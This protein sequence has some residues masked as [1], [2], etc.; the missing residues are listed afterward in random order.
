VLRKPADVGFDTANNHILVADT[1]NHLIRLYDA[2]SLTQVAAI[3]TVGHPGRDNRHLDQ[4]LSVALNETAGQIYVAD[5][6]NR[7]IQIFDAKTFAHIASLETAGTEAIFDPAANRILV[8]D[9]ARMRV[10]SYDA[11]RFT[12]LSQ[13]GTT[14]RPGNDA[15]HFAAPAAL[16]F[17][18]AAKTILVADGFPNDRVQIFEA[19]ELR[20][21]S[22]LGNTA[23]GS[24]SNNLAFSP[25]G[26]AVDPAHGQVFVSDPDNERVLVY[27]AVPY[28]IVLAATAREDGIVHAAL[29]SATAFAVSS[30]N[31]GA[32]GKLVATLDTG[33]ATLPLTATICQTGP[34]SVCL[35]PP[36]RSVSLAYPTGATPTFSVFVT[37]SAAITLN[38]SASSLFVRFVDDAG[39]VRGSVSVAV[40]A[41]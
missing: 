33:D 39:K 29:G 2:D 34:E 27:A 6:G 20:F 15:N 40:E 12:R 22:T 26:I 18:P 41:G 1:G 16:A 8:A 11:S 32:S 10:E 13:I 28:I 17:D 7:R 19:T 14:G 21:L 38:P 23:E 3:G 9:P 35:A 36:A 25:G 37:A 30:I 31:V 4:P 24:I 5:G